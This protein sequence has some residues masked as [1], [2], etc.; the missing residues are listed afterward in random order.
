MSE[1]DF[2]PRSTDTNNQEQLQRCIPCPDCV[3]DLTLVPMV[4]HCR[5]MYVTDTEIDWK[6]LMISQTE[7]LP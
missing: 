3:L 7:H 5:H 2:D 4:D 1:E 6:R